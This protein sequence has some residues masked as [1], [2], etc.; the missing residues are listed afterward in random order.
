MA[1]YT[2]FRAKSGISHNSVNDDLM[3]C[4]TFERKN[5]DFNENSTNICK[6]PEM[7]YLL[8]DQKN[9]NKSNFDFGGV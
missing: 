2:G 9:F 8:V 3:I 1:K 4:K 5:T 7:I 6:T